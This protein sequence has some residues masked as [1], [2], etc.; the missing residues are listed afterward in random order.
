MT[1]PRSLMTPL[2]TAVCLIRL[3]LVCG[4]AEEELP[5]C[6]V[7]FSLMWWQWTTWPACSGLLDPACQGFWEIRSS[8]PSWKGRV[9]PK[10]CHNSTDCWDQITGSWSNGSRHG[11]R[12]RRMEWKLRVT[13]SQP[14]G[15]P[16]WLQEHSLKRISNYLQVMPQTKWLYKNKDG[17]KVI[18]GRISIWLRTCTLKY[19]H[20]HR[21]TELCIPM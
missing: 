19:A 3:D 17:F 14:W 2:S 4:G 16:P 18:Y 9:G 6:G 21:L 13:R 8:L 1:Y 20:I 10:L 7:F 5:G 15:K 11:V 12:D